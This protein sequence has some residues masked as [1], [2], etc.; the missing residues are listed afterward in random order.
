MIEGNNA[1]NIFECEAGIHQWQR[2]PPT[3]SRG[4]THTSTVVVNVLDMIS[5]KVEISPNDIELTTTKDS[6]P[7]GQHRNKVESCVVLKYR[8]LNLIIRCANE[9]SQYQNKQT[10]YEI[11]YAKL[12]QLHAKEL[13]QAR[14]AERKRQFD[15][16]G[17]KIRSYIVKRNQVID[18]RTNNKSLLSSW[19]AGK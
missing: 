17:S 5:T 18:H 9:R 15:N 1:K 2:I 3:E 4:R 10:A 8:P 14:D 7:G 16:S 19:L 11:L 13:S 12:N 6:G